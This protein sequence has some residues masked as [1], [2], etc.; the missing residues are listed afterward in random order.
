MLRWLMYRI[1]FDIHCKHTASHLHV[2]VN[3][4][5]STDE[6]DD[7]LK[8]SHYVPNTDVYNSNSVSLFSD[9]ETTV[10]TK[11]DRRYIKQQT[12]TTK[13]VSTVK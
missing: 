9:V 12:L 4:S 6:L 10:Q 1:S 5:Q 8:D 11:V 13:L 7:S 3:V 2:S